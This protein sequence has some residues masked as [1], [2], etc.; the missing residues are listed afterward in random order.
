MRIFFFD[1]R[2]KKKKREK[3]EKR[4]LLRSDPLRSK[5]KRG[6]FFATLLSARRKKKTQLLRSAPL[7]SKKKEKN[8]KKL[9]YA[10]PPVDPARERPRGL[11][12]DPV[13][14]AVGQAVVAVAEEV[15]LRE[16]EVMVGVE[17][18]F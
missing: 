11:R 2:P 10:H 6:N 4:Q 9:N 12:E 3:R 14:D 8:P 18:L 17:L 7:R 1:A 13:D 5:E 15:L 16:E